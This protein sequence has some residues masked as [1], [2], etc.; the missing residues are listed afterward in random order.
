MKK[1]PFLVCLL[2]APYSFVL[3]T[4]TSVFW[5]NCTTDVIDTG[6]ARLNFDNYFR[7]RHPTR[8]DRFLPLD[9]GLTAGVMNV[10]N[11]K[12]EIGADYYAGQIDPFSFNG[13][14]GIEENFLCDQAPSLSVG[15]FNVGTRRGGPFR[16]NEN[17]VDL[18]IGHSL[19]DLIGGRIFFGGFSGSKAMGKNRQGF[20]AA[21]ERLFCPARDAA[22]TEYMQWA[23]LA[24]YASGKNTVGG[25]GFSLKYYFT[26][27]VSLQ[28]GPVWFNSHSI[29][30]KWKWSIQLDIVFP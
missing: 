14:I 17:I 6:S 1:I 11:I 30:G 26:P 20:M 3:G 2:L 19:P 23:F 18:V 5:T 29:Y 15:I 22:G 28:T 27:K 21:V 16:T 24:D 25:G 10:S 13:K 9:V 4:P 12:A 7:V 8:A